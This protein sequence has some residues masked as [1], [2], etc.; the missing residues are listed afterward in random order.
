MP[1]NN[2]NN[3]FK[4]DDFDEIGELIKRNR[5]LS[6]AVRANPSL[7]LA[8][9]EAVKNVAAADDAS[10]KRIAQIIKSSPHLSLASKNAAFRLAFAE[11]L[12][13]VVNDKIIKPPV[14]PPV[15]SPPTGEEPDEEAEK[16]PTEIDLEI[17]TLLN[18]IP[19]AHVGDIITSEHHNSLRRALRAIAAGAPD[20]SEQ[21]I[22]TF[23]P[24]FLPISK[25]RRERQNDWEVTFNKAVVPS[26]MGGAG[27]T[28]NGGFAV[29]MPDDALIKAMIVRGKR[30]GDA[31]NPKQFGIALSRVQLDTDNFRAELLITFDLKNEAGLFKA[32]EKPPFS[33]R[34][35]DNAKFQYFI[36]A[37]WEDEDDSARFEIYSMQ[38][39][40]D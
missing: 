21:K 4:E 9:S 17:L 23:A 37:G 29:Q 18:A 27:G 15:V 19:I 22:L 33:K 26:E 7:V 39:I 12:K 30:L 31:Q 10:D 28:V 2:F 16:P 1:R 3:A 40:C 25:A 36:T 24:N 14:K 13:A 11:L 32:T 35:V 20:V 8:I 5:A 6:V 38:I 34:T